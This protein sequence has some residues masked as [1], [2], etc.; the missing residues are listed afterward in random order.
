LPAT[1]PLREGDIFRHLTHGEAAYLPIRERVTRAAS[2]VERPLFFSTLI[3]VCAL[4]P[5]FTMKGPEGQI[6]GPMAD[7]YAF[8]LGGALLLAV[9][10]SPVL[11]TFFLKNVSP[12]PDDFLV[13]RLQRAAVVIVEVSLRHRRFVIGRVL[14]LIAVTLAALPFLGQE[15]MPELEEGNLWIHV[16]FI[17]A[18]GGGNGHVFNRL[19]L[20]KLGYQPKLYAILY[21]A[22]DQEPTRDGT[23]TKWTIDRSAAIAA[24]FA[25]IKKQLIHFPSALAC[26]TL[27]DEFTCELAEFDDHTRTVRY[28]HPDGLPDDA[29]HA[30][31]YLQAIGLRMAHESRMRWTV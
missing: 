19:L 1:Q 22:T 7:T 9:T 12:R 11:C 14:M 13:R 20:D 8:A 3:L 21:S 2:E 27:L 30:T 6:F 18:D 28:T 10:L 16:K 31:T 17:A 24:T 15:F 26:G 25:R 23:L 29:L 4:L 5:L